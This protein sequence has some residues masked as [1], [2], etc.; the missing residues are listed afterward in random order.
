[1]KLIAL[2]KYLS[3]GYRPKL[4]IIYIEPTERADMI[5][6]IRDRLLGRSTRSSARDVHF[7]QCPQGQ[8]VPCFAERC[9]N[10]RLSLERPAETRASRARA[11][12]PLPITLGA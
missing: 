5:R 11:L 9:P 8:P 2:T 12:G 7:H 3:L 1:M 4:P 10:P 6:T